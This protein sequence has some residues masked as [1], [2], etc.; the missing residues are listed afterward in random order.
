MGPEIINCDIQPSAMDTSRPL[1]GSHT[2]SPGFHCDINCMCTHQHVHCWSCGDISLWV[3]VICDT[4]R[5]WSRPT[6]IPSDINCDIQRKDA[7][8]TY[9]F[10]VSYCVTGA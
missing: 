4:P 6:V 10:I 8:G 7:L 1:R 2:S 3:G 9:F 5:H